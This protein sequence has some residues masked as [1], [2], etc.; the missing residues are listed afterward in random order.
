MDFE[1]C[2]RLCVFHSGLWLEPLQK[3]SASHEQ[4]MLWARATARPGAKDIRVAVGPVG[5]MPW[6]LPWYSMVP[7][8]PEAWWLRRAG[9]LAR[10]RREKVTRKQFTIWWH[11]GTICFHCFHWFAAFNNIEWSCPCVSGEC[12]THGSGLQR[13]IL[14]RHF[15]VGISQGTFWWIHSFAMAVFFLDHACIHISYKGNMVQVW[16]RQ[17]L[18]AESQQKEIDRTSNCI[19]HH[20]PTMSRLPA[21]F[22][23]CTQFFSH[24]STLDVEV[25]RLRPD[26]GHAHPGLQLEADLVT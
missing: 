18:T 8:F 24:V 7:W 25:I 20:S 21:E 12:E 15:L 22:L 6:Q 1:H 17:D 9:S 2:A 3:S 5:H 10:G 19:V 26:L 14:L 13:R 23:H 4:S 16:S 11:S